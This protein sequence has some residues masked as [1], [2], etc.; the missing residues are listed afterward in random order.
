MTEFSIKM[1][2]CIADWSKKAVDCNGNI[3]CLDESAKELRICLDSIFPYSK[4]IEFESD[5]V[6][7]ILSSIF[8]LASRLSKATMGLAEFD[9]SITKIEQIGKASL[10]SYENKK[11]Y[12]KFEG[13][14]NELLSK[15]F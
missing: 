4:S 12:K 13:E 1:V 3:E 14:L 6:N 2:K 11:L 9:A 15:Y 10:E 8:F 5:K 7:Y